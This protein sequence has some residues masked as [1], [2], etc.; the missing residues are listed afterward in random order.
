MALNPQQQRFCDEYL[1]VLNATQAALNA[2]YKKSTARY[3]S[4]W[5]NEN[6]N[7]QKPTD[8]KKSKFNHEMRAYIDARLEEK[9]SELIADQT[10]VLEY[11]TSVMRREKT[12]SVV[13]TLNKETST[14]VPDAEGKMRKQTVK[15]EVPEIVQIPAQLRDS[16]KAAELLGRAYGIY[17]DKVSAEITVPVMF[18]GED[19]L[20]E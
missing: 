5:I 20:Q 6:E 12:E 9:A 7:P 18:A 4:K 16:N 10:E 2:G 15:E 3:A 8:G 13:V 17:T 19:D 11:L 14:Y 1:K